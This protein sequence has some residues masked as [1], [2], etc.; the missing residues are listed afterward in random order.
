M[1]KDYD[2]NLKIRVDD[3]KSIFGADKD[4]SHPDYFN[5]LDL[6]NLMLRFYDYLKNYGGDADLRIELLD[7][8]ESGAISPD[9]LMA[10]T[11]IGFNQVDTTVGMIGEKI[12]HGESKIKE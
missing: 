8:L 11:V 7:G 5:P 9:N 6:M 2:I 4:P 3:T 1:V 10:L 12:L